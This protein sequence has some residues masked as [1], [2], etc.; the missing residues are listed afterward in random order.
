MRGG[1]SPLATKLF[2]VLKVSVLWLKTQLGGWKLNS[3]ALRRVRVDVVE[4][5]EIG[6][7]FQ[8]AEGR[9]AVQRL[10]RS[11]PPRRPAAAS[12]GDGG[13][14]APSARKSRR[15]MLARRAQLLLLYLACSAASL[16]GS[17]HQEFDVD[18][19]IA[20]LLLGNA[21]LVPVGDPGLRQ[22]PLR[23]DVVVPQ[24]HAVERVGGG[25]AGRRGR[26]RR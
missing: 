2:S 3:A 1:A 18:A 16:A 4:M 11:A 5:R 7:V 26:W 24:Q 15:E 8:V 6:R 22:V 23:H 12:S 19:D 21:E 10:V 9:Q 14:G 20:R 13:R 25:D 17:I